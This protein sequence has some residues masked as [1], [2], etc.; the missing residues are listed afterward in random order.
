MLFVVGRGFVP[1]EDMARLVDDSASGGDVSSA[2]FDGGEISPSSRPFSSIILDVNETE[3]TNE[4][5][6]Q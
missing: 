1:L 5:I 4:N 2:I 3:R 6:G